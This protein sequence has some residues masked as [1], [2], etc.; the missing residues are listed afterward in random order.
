[1]VDV[2]FEYK[3]SAEDEKNG[4]D[5]GKNRAEISIFALE[6]AKKLH[7]SHNRKEREEDFE[8]NTVK[9]VKTDEG[10]DKDADSYY[11]S[12]AEIFIHNK[13]IAHF[14]VWEEVSFPQGG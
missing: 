9:S 8:G 14:V 1:M 10:D 6:E 7:E 5:H 11:Y 3:N 13:I 4:L 2:D 12:H